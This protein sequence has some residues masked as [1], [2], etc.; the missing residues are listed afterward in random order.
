MERIIPARL[1]HSGRAG[2]FVRD[3]S[4][5]EFPGQEW[6]FDAVDINPRFRVKIG[7]QRA[8]CRFRA[9]CLQTGRSPI[10]EFALKF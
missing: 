3:R 1:S 7:D 8:S 5:M 9:V 2:R 4:R 10:E 6:D